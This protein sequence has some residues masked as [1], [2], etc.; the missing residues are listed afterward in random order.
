MRRDEEE[1]E[2]VE[3]AG[4]EDRVEE[5]K[6]RDCRLFIRGWENDDA[7]ASGDGGDIRPVARGRGRG[8][9]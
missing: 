3:E 2:E 7:F 6:R 1:E 5:K 8:L 4:E 9:A